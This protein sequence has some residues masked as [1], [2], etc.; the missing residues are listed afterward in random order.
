LGSSFTVYATSK[1]RIYLFI[2]ICGMGVDPIGKR[3]SWIS[4]LK[5]MIHGKLSLGKKLSYAYAI[6]EPG[7]NL[8]GANATEIK[9]KKV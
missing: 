7:V 4:P 9:S 2:F 1:V 6:K 8:T 3:N 5:K